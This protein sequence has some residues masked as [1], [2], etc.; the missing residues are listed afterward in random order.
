MGTFKSFKLVQ[1]N[2]KNSASAV[3]KKTK[4]PKEKAKE[5][6]VAGSNCHYISLGSMCPVYIKSHTKN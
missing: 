1:F 5:Q 6:Y 2:N 4:I 3:E